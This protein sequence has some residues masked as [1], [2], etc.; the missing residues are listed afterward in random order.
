MKTRKKNKKL[1]GL[2]IICFSIFGLSI[3]LMLLTSIN[4]ITSIIGIFFHLCGMYFASK[5]GYAKNRRF[6]SIGLDAYWNPANPYYRIHRGD[7]HRNKIF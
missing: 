7:N 1:L 5:S 6:T 3:L 2:S 4:T